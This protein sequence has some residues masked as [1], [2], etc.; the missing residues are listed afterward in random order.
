MKSK[1][2]Q[3][4]VTA[5]ALVL[6]AGFTMQ[7]SAFTYDQAGGFLG[8]TAT[9]VPG[10]EF[11]NPIVDPLAPANTYSMI[12]WDEAETVKSDLRIETFE[13][14]IDPDGSWVTISRLFHDNNVILARS[15]DLDSVDISTNLRI[16]DG[17]T[18]VLLDPGLITI[19]FNETFNNINTGNCPFGNPLGSLCDDLFSFAL[20][21]FAP[22]IFF[23]NNG[24]KYEA[25]FGLDNFVNSATDFPSC[26]TYPG[27]CTVWTA[28]ATTS[29]M[30]VV[31]SI[32]EVPE[33]ASLALIGIGLL[34]FGIASRRKSRS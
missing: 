15:R 27:T 25:I 6:G 24:T 14:S 13:G 18:E 19:T 1:K 16:Y 3:Q 30:D 9:P 31:M 33:P 4:V 26:D 7:A 12:Q 17:A 32:Q 20:T 29:S 10:V 2:L 8:G 34:G 22:V 5:T 23:D 21:G 28:E 11:V